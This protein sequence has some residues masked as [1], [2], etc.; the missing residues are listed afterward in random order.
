MLYNKF[1]EESYD[2]VNPLFIRTIFF[3]IRTDNDDVMG[4]L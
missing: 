2:V 1:L 3:L 4:C